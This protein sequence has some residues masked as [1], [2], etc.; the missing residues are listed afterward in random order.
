MSDQTQQ[1]VADFKRWLDQVVARG[2]WRAESDF[3]APNFIVH[4]HTGTKRYSREEW[5]DERGLAIVTRPGV[6]RRVHY[7]EA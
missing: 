2:D 6:C 5:I 7:G 1:T 3:I 4:S